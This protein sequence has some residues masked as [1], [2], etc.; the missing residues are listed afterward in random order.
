MWRNDDGLTH[1]IV[2][3]DGSFDTGN[4]PAGA[5]SSMVQPSAGGYHCLIHPSMVGSIGPAGG[6]TGGGGDSG[7]GGEELP[8][9]LGGR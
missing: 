4:L 1:R 9:A 6:G 3:D 2:A 8:Y 5:T 7:A